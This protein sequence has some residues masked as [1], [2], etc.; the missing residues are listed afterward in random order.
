M[1]QETAYGMA[2]EHAE[3]GIMRFLLTSAGSSI[4]AC[5]GE[6]RV[7]VAAADEISP[8]RAIMRATH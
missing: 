1:T 4:Q 5:E 8:A 6:A 7:I 2:Q 3:E